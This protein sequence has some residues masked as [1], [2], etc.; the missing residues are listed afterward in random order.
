PVQEWGINVLRWIPTRNEDIDWVVVPRN[1]TGYASR[2]GLL[3]GIEG[4]HPSRR[5]EI[6]PYVATSGTF[7][8]TPDP[9]DPFDPDGRS[10]TGRV[11][12]D[13]KMGLGPN[14]TLDATINP[15]FGQV[16]ADPAEV[17]L[18]AFETF[19]D[20][21]RPFFTEGSQLLRSNVA[22]YFYSRRIGG[23]PHTPLEGDYLDQPAFTTILGAAKLSGQLKGGLSIAGL[24]ALTQRESGRVHDIATDATREAVVEPRTAYGVARVQQ[25]FG[26]DASTVGA[27]V[28]GMNR[29]FAG[30]STLRSSIT[31]RAVAGGV[32]WVLRFRR[33]EYELSGDVGGSYVR[34][35]RE[36]ILS[37]QQASSRYL[38][39]PDFGYMSVDS[40]R[41]SLSGYRG[42]I[43]LDKN[44]G[45]WLFGAE[46]SL[47]SPGFET[48]DMGRIQTVDDIDTNADV[49]Y[50][51]TQ[52]TDLFRN[53]RLGVFHRSS[54]NFDGVRTNT[55]LGIFSRFTWLNFMSSSFNL[56]VRP[57]SQSDNLTRGGPLMPVP[58][59]MEANAS[60][61]SSFASPTQ[62]NLSL[63]HYRDELGG[64]QWRFR[65]GLTVR[66]NSALSVSINPSYLRV[67]DAQQYITTLENGPAATFGSRYVFGRI[68][69]STLSAQLRVNYTFAPDLSLEVYAEPFA[70]SGKYSQIG[71]LASPRSSDR[72][73]YGEGPTTVVESPEGLTVTDSRN[74]ETFFIDGP[75]FNA[76]SFRSNMVL[77]WEWR[78]GSTLFLVWQQSR[79]A[80]CS[81]ADPLACPGVEHPGSLVGI[82][83]LRDSLRSTGDN[84]LA[85][86][87]TYWIGLH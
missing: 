39:R 58:A 70:A 71:E 53:A 37:L 29:W 31:S 18:T 81:P 7:A 80:F 85:I 52:P 87:A 3:T 1:E 16:E 84:F 12:A 63:N 64:R 83:S 15:D 86:K 11:G 60:L 20:E 35:S 13:L 22:D 45:N 78:P 50:R 8:G 14:L 27:V 73:V 10:L 2:F 74:G 82:G 66:P 5:I 48:N 28:S 75:D 9:D 25:Q 40:A 49:N 19:F 55:L 42:R 56:N 21:R 43:R 61:N 72:T 62:W 69:R 6:S 41:T 36:A 57:R 67:I 54:W 79:S 51:W 44:A 23:R 33:G 47:Q 17:N 26:R 46:A 77:R 38:Q 30:D 34:G 32:D 65:T 59:G 4:I 24:A 76:L 68:E